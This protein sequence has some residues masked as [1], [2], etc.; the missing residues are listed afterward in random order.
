MAETEVDRMVVRLIGDDTS[1]DRM[2]KNAVKGTRQATKDVEQ[3]T[4]R[5]EKFAGGLK[6]VGASMARAGRNLSVAV[7]APIV[8]LGFV[9]VKAFNTQERAEKQLEAALESN[10]REVKSLLADYKQFASALQGITTVGDETTLQ[11]LQQAEAM[12]LSGE[13]AKR[14]SKNAIALAKAMGLNEKSALRYTASLEQGTTTMLNRYLPVLKDIEDDTERAAK[15]QQLLANMF[16][17]AEAEAKTFGGVVQQMK[18][19]LGDLFEEFGGIIAEA[20][21]PFVKMLSQVVKWFQKLSPATKKW[22]VGIAALVATLGPALVALGGLVAA[23]GFVISGAAALAPLLAPIGAFLAAWAIPIGIAVAAVT[24]LVGAFNGFW[25]LGDIVKFVVEVVKSFAVNMLVAV[26]TA[27]R[28]FT[29]LG[30]WILANVPRWFN[31][32]VEFMIPV[33]NKVFDVVT[34]A[35]VAIATFVLDT[36]SKVAVLLGELFVAAFT[37]NFDGVKRAVADL[38]NGIL[39]SASEAASSFAKQFSKDVQEGAKT[40]DIAGSLSNVLKEQMAKVR[41]PSFLKGLFGDGDGGDGIED[42]GTK[43]AAGIEKID[44]AV[45]KLTK[46]LNIMNNTAVRG[47]TKAFQDLQKNTLKVLAQNPEIAEN[48]ERDKK[49]RLE[50]AAIEAKRIAKKKLDES[51]I[52][53]RGDTPEAFEARKRKFDESSPGGRRVGEGIAGSTK[54]LEEMNAGMKE[55]VELARAD[56]EKEGVELTSG[57]IFD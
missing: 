1:Y 38:S 17:V 26:E 6:A 45:K 11:M 55:L 13:S 52:R 27:I 51:F 12:G 53:G 16:K 44:E 15:A 25:T 22:I 33:M 43:G 14:A 39:E 8:A 34:S 19:D 7:T 37:G 50:I 3:M 49:R 30:A 57:G 23:L 20:L 32:F 40:E 48:A 56:A 47:N 9:A 24:A 42:L 28:I 31:Q 46:D 4:K 2:L 41:V 5:M 10:G 36:F 54:P 18:N 29:V 35:F 21:T